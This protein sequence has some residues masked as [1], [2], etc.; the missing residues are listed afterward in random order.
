[1]DSEI[2]LITDTENMEKVPKVIKHAGICT[3]WNI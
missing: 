2:W 3:L 1:M